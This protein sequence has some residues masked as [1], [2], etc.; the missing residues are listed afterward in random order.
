M[1]RRCMK[2]QQEGGWA[3]GRWRLTLLDIQCS[4]RAIQSGCVW[5]LW[6]MSAATKQFKIVVALMWWL[7]SLDLKIYW[8]E[9][10]LIWIVWIVI[11]V[12]AY[13]CR[14]DAEQD[15]RSEFVNE[16]VCP[17]MM[18]R[19]LGTTSLPLPT[20]NVDTNY[21]ILTIHFCPHHLYTFYITSHFSYPSTKLQHSHYCSSRELSEESVYRQVTDVDCLEPIMY[22]PIESFPTKPYSILNSQLDQ[23][24]SP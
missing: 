1:Q 17:W 24:L 7:L 23:Q 16:P 4:F 3:Q 15:Y 13:T 21:I 6:A 19:H 14:T 10:S 12:V 5:E 9:L 18:K 2:D 11:L 20:T 8:R 22:A